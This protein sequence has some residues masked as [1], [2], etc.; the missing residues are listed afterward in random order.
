MLRDYPT[1]RRWE[2][3]DDVLHHALLRLGRALKA[4]P[5]ESSRHFWNVA[6]R[7]VRLALIDLARHYGGPEGLGANHH[8]DHARAADDPGGALLRQAANTRE[9]S[10]P[11]E[12]A[13]FLEKVQSL[14]DRQR[15]VFDLLWVKGHTQE[16]AA[17][18][19]GVSVRTVKR[20]WQEARISLDGR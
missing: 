7:H 8:T 5:F 12:W 19:L 11:A 20:L 17:L 6:A 1:V 3:T 9:P 4:V 13:E 16:D 2:Q 15:E 10:S 18:V 14:P